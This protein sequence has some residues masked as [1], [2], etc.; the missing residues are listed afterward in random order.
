MFHDNQW[1]FLKGNHFFVIYIFSTCV[2]KRYTEKTFYRSVIIKKTRK[3]E[4]FYKTYYP[5]F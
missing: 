4:G 1:I 3:Y 2:K 5:Y